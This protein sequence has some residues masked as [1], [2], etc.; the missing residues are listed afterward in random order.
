MIGFDLLTLCADIY[1]IKNESKHAYHSFDVLKN[2]NTEMQQRLS[3]CKRLRSMPVSSSITAL[4][5][6]D[7]CT[8]ITDRNVELFLEFKR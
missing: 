2:S 3:D 4:R 7:Y 1:S 8:N 5:N 6:L